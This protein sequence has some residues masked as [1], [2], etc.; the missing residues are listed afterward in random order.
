LLLVTTTG[1]LTAPTAAATGRLALV[2]ATTVR[3]LFT[4]V[5]RRF[6]VAVGVEAIRALATVHL[7]TKTTL[8][9]LRIGR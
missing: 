4:A 7:D 1:R 8:H 5:E 3:A 2:S 6:L 9:G